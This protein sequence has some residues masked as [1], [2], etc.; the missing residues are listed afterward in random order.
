[1]SKKGTVTRMAF[2]YF[3]RTAT[4]EVDYPGCEFISLEGGPQPE[5][6][7]VWS[8]L[9]PEPALGL[10][11]LRNE[12]IF[13]ADHLPTGRKDSQGRPIITTVI[14]QARNEEDKQKLG[15]FFAF[16][17]TNTAAWNEFAMQLETLVVQP[18]LRGGGWNGALP[19]IE[20]F[21]NSAPL[22]KLSIGQWQH[23][24]ADLQ[25]RIECAQKIATLTKQGANF[26]IGCSYYS[27]LRIQQNLLET[28]R[29]N[30][31]KTYVE[32]FSLQTTNST[33][34]TH[35]QTKSSLLWVIVGIVLFLILILVIAYCR[36]YEKSMAP[37]TEMHTR[38]DENKRD[39]TQDF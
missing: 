15:Q 32:I 24:Y 21:S 2:Q 23:P 8:S 29:F 20:N 36:T 6:N 7:R 3:L 28:Y 31:K 13:S 35:Q 11:A 39:N 1:M 16:L 12:L 4:K 19:G 17:L 22:Y 26:A 9:S 33:I 25:M 30:W 37:T 18:I 27:A 14:V 38:I 34:L 10:V 5:A